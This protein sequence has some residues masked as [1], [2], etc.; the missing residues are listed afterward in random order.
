VERGIDPVTAASLC[1]LTEG[2]IVGLRLAAL[3]MQKGTNPEVILGGFRGDTSDF[4]TDYLV[5]EVLKKQSTDMREFL[6]QTS[7]LNRFNA[8][9]SDAVCYRSSTEADGSQES[10]REVLSTLRLIS[11]VNNANLFLIPLGEEQGW[12]RYHHLFQEM[13]RN[14]L[15]SE[16]SRNQVER[17]HCRASHWFADHGYLDEAIGH[18]LSANDINLAVN[19]VEEQSQNLLNLFDRNVLERWLSILPEEVVWMRPKLQITRAWILYRQFNITVLESVL[20]R[21]EHLI[22]EGKCSNGEKKVVGSH[23]QALRCA[24]EYLL[25]ANYTK[26]L[27]L[28]EKALRQLP[29]TDRGARSVAF[30]FRALSYQAL[31]DRKLAIRE[32]EQIIADLSPHSPA[33][34]QAYLSL[35]LL[36]LSAGNLNRMAQV[37]KQMFSFAAENMEVNAMP[38]ANY[39]SGFLYYEWD[40]LDVAEVYFQRVFDARYRANF[41]GGM[42]GALGLIRINQLRHQLE[43]SQELLEILRADVTKI[44]NADLLP[45]V[46]AAQALQDMLQGEHAAALRWARTKPEVP[47]ADKIFNT[48]LP[49]MIECR[50]L[51]ALGTTSELQQLQEHLLQLKLELESYH[52]TNHLVQV[53]AHL[54]LMNQ[55]LGNTT[56]ALEYLEQAVA[57]AQPGGLVRSIVDVG[58]LIVPLLQQLHASDVA[59]NY[60]SKLLLA[61]D[62]DQPNVSPKKADSRSIDPDLTD[63]AEPLSR[64]EQDVIRLM[65]RGLSNQEIAESLF[66]SPHTVRAHAT[67]IYAKLG[68]NSRARAVHKARQLGILPIDS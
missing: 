61:F 14:R 24:T 46:E 13:L 48:E 15:N 63:L 30:G 65:G 35:A 33:K 16:Y 34:S 53:L 50:I 66:I 20:D 40:D 4:I 38:V 27:N 6:L 43:K 62:D 21:I 67:N 23:V 18:A 56:E 7:I 37:T 9:L 57:V 68:V 39:T 8:N 49:I 47:F 55:R 3:S 19:L 26:V 59:P 31:G 12:Y 11:E 44:M 42:G 28:S 1:Q 32:L 45:W 60:V 17:L 51:V 58:P 41:M 2:W 29:E 52:F 22:D 64:R 54:A 10:D 5:S 36:H 25:N